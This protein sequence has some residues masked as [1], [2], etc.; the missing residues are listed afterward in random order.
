MLHARGSSMAIMVVGETG[1]GKTSLLSNLFHRGLEWPSGSRTPAIQEQTV[2]FQLGG[3][4]DEGSV[5]F[6]A[7]LIDSP[8]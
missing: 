8:G 3:G 1:V 6:E 7:H 2:R 4:K 5:P